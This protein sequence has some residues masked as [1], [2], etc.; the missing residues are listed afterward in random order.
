MV[1]YKYTGKET[2]AFATITARLGEVAEWLKA[3]ASKAVVRSNRTEGSNPS[4]SAI[5]L[6][7]QGNLTD[8]H[9][10]V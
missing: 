6:Y 2:P 9:M 1:R 7:L 4:L 3:A 10:P 5:I 8:S